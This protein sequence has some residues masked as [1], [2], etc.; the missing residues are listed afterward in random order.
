[1]VAVHGPAE[2][3]ALRAT[4]RRRS[5]PTI[6]SSSLFALTLTL[7]ASGST[8]SARDI[9]QVG[10]VAVE[11]AEVRAHLAGEATPVT[12]REAI[13]QAVDDRLL[14]MEALQH[15][16]ETEARRPGAP[17]QLLDTLFPPDTVCKRIPEPMRRAHYA[18]T[19]W[20]FQ[21]PPAWRVSSI[22]WSCCRGPVCD[23]PEAAA[24]N[25]RGRIMLTR[26]RTELPDKTT[27]A[28]FGA[29]H[30]DAAP[31]AP[32]LRL[33]RYTYFFDPDRPQERPHRRLRT[34]ATVIADAMSKATPG[35][36]VGPVSTPR[37]H[38]ILRLR[39]RLPRVD[40]PWE[41][42]R[43]QAV[44]RTEL[45]PALWLRARQQYL[46]DLRNQLPVRLDID[47]IRDAFGVTL[48]DDVDATK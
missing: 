19:V 4:V 8:A 22:G 40:L 10:G 41:D 34:A 46:S 18:D 23:H 27:D 11:D 25:E 32:G 44:L 16:G 9:G 1:M 13:R 7:F 48:T 36:I 33:E 2:Q 15:L 29:A 6:G 12:V 39:S 31:T 45:C 21:M 5:R 24:C 47:A 14:R 26:L 30:A 28:D 42:D 43:T 37:G 35:E 17:A 38:Y 3:E 20:R